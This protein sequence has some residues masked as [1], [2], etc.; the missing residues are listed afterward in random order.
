M[1]T[2]KE[3]GITMAALSSGGAPMEI[4]GLSLKD[5]VEGIIEAQFKPV[6][7]DIK[8]QA[9][10][11]EEAAEEIKATKDRLVEFFT[12]GA[13]KIEIE[14]KI[15]GIQ[16]AVKEVFDQIKSIPTQIQ[17]MLAK[18]FIPPTIPVIPTAP[19][20]SNPIRDLLSNK[21][22]FEKVKQVVTLIVGI[23]VTLFAKAN[24]LSFVLP[25]AVQRMATQIGNLNSIISKIPVP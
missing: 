5:I 15:A 2:I 18:N 12:S 13:A 20:F 23:L 10:N 9:E 8:A 21:E 19:G 6:F 24:E 22:N 4:P 16:Q 11:A 7:D 14:N 3:Q 17:T 25:D 1:A